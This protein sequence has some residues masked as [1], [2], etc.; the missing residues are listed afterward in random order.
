MEKSQV[1]LWTDS[2]I[3]LHWIKSSAKPWKSFVENRVREI[4]G[5]TAPAQWNHCSGSENPA[6]VATRGTSVNK[7]KE[8]SL[9]WTGPAWLKQREINYC[10][11][12]VEPHENDKVV[13]ENLLVVEVMGEQ[14]SLRS[15]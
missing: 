6:D 11:T 3:T 12:E 10:E 9:W 1:K 4:Q 13:K 8:N 7:L 14:E 15:T 5:P 2:V